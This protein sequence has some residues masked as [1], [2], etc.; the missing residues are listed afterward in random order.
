MNPVPTAV[1]LPGLLAGQAEAT[2][3]APALVAGEVRWTYRQLDERVDQ[4]AARLAALGVRAGQTVGLL[5][6]NTADWLAVA[7]GALR[8][9]ARLDAFHTWVKAWEWEHLLRSSACVTLV[10]VGSVRSADLL[11][12]LRQVLPELWEAPPG[13][14]G[15]DRFPALREVALLS[16]DTPPP[17]ARSWEEL[18][19]EG[20]RAGAEPAGHDPAFVLYT[21][22]STATPK[23]VPLTHRDLILNGF[24]IGERMGLTAGDRVWLGSPLFWSF[25]SANALMATLTHGAC[26][27]LQE[28]FQPEETARLW[29]RE[30]CTAA[31]L[32]PRMVDDLAP[33]AQRV[34]AVRS[35]RTG[36]T[37]GR[38]E[39]VL[40]VAEEL[41]VPEICNV[42][43]STETYG[44]CCVTPHH[45]PLETRA[46]TQGPPLPGVRLR[47][48]T[49][50]GLVRYEDATGELQVRGRIT[51]GYL[52]EPEATAAVMTE[53][54]WFRT[55]DRVTLRPDGAVEFRGR[56]TEMIKT[57]GINVSP[58]EVES[59]LCRHPRVRTAA[60]VGAPHHSR[61]EV[62]VA[63]V[64][65]DGGVDAEELRDF[66][67]RGIAGYK[68]PR[69]IVVLPELPTTVTGKLQR[70]ALVEEAT[71]RVGP[72]ERTPEPT[73]RTEPTRREAG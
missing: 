16:G 71:R 10:T 44:N 64:T 53:D 67:Q 18:P 27:V 23:A 65:T 49:P 20:D 19:G 26:L 17:G 66:C 57:S 2:P 41:G 43:G 55:G 12:E 13:R 14:W 73:Q 6:G 11:A 28:R 52:G 46:T 63:F 4:S 15:S 68:V 1:H 48:V 38:A 58:A 5:A 29:E 47:V 51:P 9:G 3:D 54:G 32:L 59:Y 31:Y 24:H 25:G 72:A 62:V 22:G 61:G 69:Q 40:R 56:L 45:L 42:Y 30:E 50:E 60:V 37:I 7:L 39:E 33:V 21:S 34:R 70:R 36:L 35:L 8:L